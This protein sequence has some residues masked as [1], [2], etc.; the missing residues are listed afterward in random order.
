M[1]TPSVHSAA[2]HPAAAS[3]T[4]PIQ[5]Q[6]AVHP[7]AECIETARLLRALVWG[8]GKRGVM[9]IWLGTLV[10]AGTLGA[11]LPLGSS[12]QSQPPNRRVVGKMGKVRNA[13]VFTT[14]SS[15]EFTPNSISPNIALPSTTPA[16]GQ[17]GITPT[18]KPATPVINQQGFTP[19]VG[20]G[21]QGFTPA[22][23]QQGFAPA[24]GQQGIIIGQPEPFEPAPPIPSPTGLATSSRFGQRTFGNQ[25]TNAPAGPAST[26]PKP[27]MKRTTSVP[28]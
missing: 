3:K 27:L 28:R 6:G 11:L 22:L 9:K 16:L 18:L 4:S 7:L 1:I 25:G 14:N 26:S 8:P 13:A 19:A 17:Q 20:Q 21:P 5:S 2:E 10:L 12:A 15:A 23:G 24:I